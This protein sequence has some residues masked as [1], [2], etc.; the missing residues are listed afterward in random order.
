L[1]GSS[2]W[3]VG[4]KIEENGTNPNSSY[5]R[6]GIQ[7]SMASYATLWG[8]NTII[9]N[10]GFGVSAGGVSTVQIGSAWGGVPARNTITGNAAG[11]SGNNGAHLYIFDADIS[12]NM[13]TGLNLWHRSSANIN[14]STINSNAGNG[15][16][17][18]FRSSANINESTVNNNSGNGILLNLGGALVLQINPTVTVTGNSEFGLQCNDGESSY[19]GNTDSITGNGTGDVSGTCTGF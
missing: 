12:N 3:I 1:A 18:G 2:A 11:V 14:A 19:A 7:V 9:N 8:A 6:D 17:L 13:G 15:V 10:K 4:N 16:I 5:G